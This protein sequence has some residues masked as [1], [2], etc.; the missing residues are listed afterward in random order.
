MQKNTSLVITDNKP[1]S[2]RGQRILDVAQT[3]FYQQGYDE[4]S[5]AMIIEQ[6]GGSR[7]S[8]YAEFGNKQGLLMA[9][10]QRQVQS[11]TQIL[12][13][14][15]RR[16]DV[17]TALNQVAFNFVQG[18]LSPEL[19]ALFR[20]AV[21]QVVKFPELGKMIHHKG[22]ITGILPL[23]DYLAWLKAEKVLKID[24]CH[25]SAQIL[26]EMAKGPLHTQC[27]LLPDKKIT[28]EEIA[29]QVAKVVNIFLKSHRRE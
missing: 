6:A 27:L 5:L 7:R 29:E 16:L 14:I 21:Q 3:F 20:L 26:L 12:T 19:M 4:T 23:V 28:D 11:Q 13:K 2:K 22:P 18:M 15:N 25:F 1:L 17:K 10:V 8:I 9:V 24:D